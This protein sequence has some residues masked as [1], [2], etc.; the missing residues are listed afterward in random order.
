MSVGSRPDVSPSLLDAL[1]RSREWGFLGDG[2]VESHVA[3]AIGFAE[4]AEAA[5]DVTP[6]GERSLGPWM[7]L[8]SGGGIPGLILA[9]RWPDRE[10]VLLDSSERRTSF[11]S[12]IIA[13]QGWDDRVT[14][15]TDRAELAG[16]TAAYR[17]AFTLVVARSFGSPPVTAE[18]AAPFLRRGGVLV[19]SEPPHSSARNE[20]DEVRWPEQ[21]LRIVGL[22]R[23]SL[24]RGE[25]GYALLRQAEDCP[26]RFPRRVGVPGKRPIYGTGGD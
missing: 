2:P 18:C 21:G 10:A 7:D 11:L 22:T 15:V 8:G 13:D 20:L 4:A 25:F 26:D 12:Q 17:G 24:R 9:N 19:V 5:P 6:T 1:R 14:I 23:L 16:R 3:H